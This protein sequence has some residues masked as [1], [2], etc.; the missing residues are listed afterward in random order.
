MSKLYKKVQELL[1][2]SEIPYSR[3]GEATGIRYNTI[4]RIKDPTN[5][6]MPAV[7]TCEKLYE[8]L[9]GKQLEV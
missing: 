9:T 5:T 3:I 8:F 1:R 6:H 2:D 4:L 7:D